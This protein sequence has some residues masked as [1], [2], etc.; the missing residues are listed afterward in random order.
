MAEAGAG[1]ECAR[2]EERG[3]EVEENMS[4]GMSFQFWGCGAACE[5]R[6]LG[7]GLGEKVRETVREGGAG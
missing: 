6:G 7:L 4:S 1:V 5:A 2:R 3:R